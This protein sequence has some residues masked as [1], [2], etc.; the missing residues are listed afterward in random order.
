MKVISGTLKGRTIKGFEI[1]GTR[2]TMDRVKESLF[3]M[4]QDYIED[5]KVLDL[6]SGS[7]N[8]GIEAISNGAKRV[9][10]NDINKIAVKTIRTNLEAFGVIDKAIITCM[11]YKTYLKE[12]KDAFDIIFLDP[13]YKDK[14][15]NEII[16]TIIKKNLIKENGLIV[17]EV[18]EDYLDDFSTLERIKQRRYG[19]K[20]II[21]YKK[22]CK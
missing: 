1:V 21:I 10:F 13:P 5:S 18:S 22:T 7:G 14:V 12:T 4:I 11:D 17:C 19:D 3:A 16:E 8:L 6:F 2:P 15:L 20:E 9:C